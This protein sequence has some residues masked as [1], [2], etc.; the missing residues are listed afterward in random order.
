MISC[1]PRVRRLPSVEL[2]I[3]VGFFAAVAACAITALVVPIGQL[4]VR[5]AVMG[6]AGCCY[7]AFAAD[8]RAAAVMGLVVWTL[9]TGFLIQPAGEL[10]VTGVPDVLRFAAVVAMCLAG[11]LYGI[12]RRRARA[13]GRRVERRPGLPQPPRT[14]PAL[15]RVPPRR[16]APVRSCP[17]GPAP[18]PPAGRSGRT[19]PRCRHQGG[20]SG[21]P[22]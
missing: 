19:L 13:G 15:R 14:R 22:R 16:Y 1:S 8:L 4:E 21:P 20:S 7:A 2:S 6:L 9:A 18:R 17:G 5:F 11:G 10:I 3:G 12:A